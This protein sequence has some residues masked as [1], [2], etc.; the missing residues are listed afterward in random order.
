M[1]I[2]HMPFRG[3]NSF[4]LLNLE[5]CSFALQGAPV[6]SKRFAASW[7]PGTLIQA[8]T[9]LLQGMIQS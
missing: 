2:Q 5:I 7:W 6:L 9:L 3:Q 8:M 1:I 4:L